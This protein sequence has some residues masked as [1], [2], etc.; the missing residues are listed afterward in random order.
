MNAEDISREVNAAGCFAPFALSLNICFVVIFAAPSRSSGRTS[1]FSMRFQVVRAKAAC[2]VFET[3]LRAK[4][5][6]LAAMVKKL[7]K[8]DKDGFL[9]QVNE[10]CVHFRG[11]CATCDYIQLLDVI[12]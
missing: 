1:T 3:I 10:D 8:P 11:P 4:G 6:Q 5:K 2:E 7:P 12:V 9:K